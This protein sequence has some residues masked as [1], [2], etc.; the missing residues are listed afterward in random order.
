[1]AKHCYYWCVCTCTQDKAFMSVM[2]FFFQCRQRFRCAPPTSLVIHRTWSDSSQTSRMQQ[3]SKVLFQ[4]S[5]CQQR[6]AQKDVEKMNIDVCLKES[7][8]ICYITT[9][10]SSPF[11]GTVSEGSHTRTLNKKIIQSSTELVI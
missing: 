9:F 1:M 2:L 8:F 4:H 7:F 11:Q 10:T 6:K 3:R 5:V